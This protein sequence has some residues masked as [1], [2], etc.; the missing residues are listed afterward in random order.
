MKFKI[1]QYNTPNLPRSFHVVD[2]DG[3]K[4]TKT[5]MDEKAAQTWL[6]QLEVDERRFAI[7]DF[8]DLKGETSK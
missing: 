2:S 4:R 6:K 5:T 8:P 7:L 3:K 1:D